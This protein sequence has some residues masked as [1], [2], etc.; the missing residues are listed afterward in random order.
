M[1][2]NR[3]R[4]LLGGAASLAAVRD[5]QAAQP[6]RRWSQE[7]DVVV[8]GAGAAGYAT[9]I[10]AREAGASIAL[11]ETQPH[12]GGH[13]IISGGNVALGGGTSQQ[14]QYGIEDSPDLV[15]RDLTDWSAVNAN[16][17]SDYR[18]NDREIVRVFADHSAPTFEWLKAH[19]VVFVDKAPDPAGGISVG[20]SA[21]REHHAAPMDWLI[22]QSGRRATPERRTTASSGAGLMWPLD[23][24]ARK[25]GVQILLEHRMVELLREQP[26]SGRI[27]GVRATHGGRD[28]AIRARKAVMLATGGSTGNVSFRRMI[29]PRLTDEYC[30]LAGMP[31]SDQDASGELA[32]MAVG[33]SL[34]GFAGQAGEYGWTLTKASLIGTQWGYGN[35]TW[36]PECAV[37]DR[38]RAKGLRVR[39]W[40]NVILV[41]MLGE[42]FYDETAPG[43]PYNN[44]GTLKDHVA[45]TARSAVPRDYRAANFLNAALAGFGDGHNGGGPIWAIFD[46]DAAA[47]EGWHCEPPWVDANAGFFF[48]ADT[49]RELAARIVM[50]H[51]RRPMPPE[52]LEATVARYNSFVD[53]G[54]DADF[55]KPAPKF[56]IARP[57]FYAAWSTP[58]VH[59]T[60]SGLRIDARCRVLDFAG[61]PIPGLYSGGET[62][63]GL[64]V[65][66]LARALC[67]GYIAGQDIATLRT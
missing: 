54:R 41:N 50:P 37:F 12:I 58:V 65:H 43:Y 10:V 49:L 38:V 48:Q 61:E 36:E 15:F 59:D 17:V 39:D 62:A 20:N 44:Y 28:V 29:D 42:R 66:G 60:R 63:G 57:P 23:A 21:P 9:A 4:M 40:Q 64:S 53:A 56:R 26:R 25:A 13:A 1:K 52:A 67:Q 27:T 8:V 47:R 3:R 32:A 18:Y 24:A 7:V 19:G 51:Q 55:D 30:G 22:V 46:A 31:W 35:V 34:W 11:L 45:H 33:A 16:G 14:R 6:R 5:A 2:V